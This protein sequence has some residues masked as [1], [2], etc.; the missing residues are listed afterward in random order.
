MSNEPRLPDVRRLARAVV[1]HI[2]GIF[3]LPLFLLSPFAAITAYISMDVLVSLFVI[4]IVYANI[5]GHVVLFAILARRRVLSLLEHGSDS[6]DGQDPVATT[7]S[8]LIRIFLIANVSFVLVNA[9]LLPLFYDFDFPGHVLISPLYIASF[10]LVVMPALLSSMV[11]RCENAVRGS[12]PDYTGVGVRIG[13]RL[14]WVVMLTIVGLVG[15]SLLTNYI[16]VVAPEIGREPPVT[17][18]VLNLILGVTSLAVIAVVVMQVRS[19]VVRPLREAI[20]AFEVALDGDFTVRTTATTLDEIGQL[21]AAADSFFRSMRSD[22]QTIG[23]VIRDL[24]Q[25]KSALSTQVKAVAESV[26]VIRSQLD[27]T[28][29]QMSDQTANMSE[30]TAAI[31]ELARNIDSLGDSISAQHDHVSESSASVRGLSDANTKLSAIAG[32]SQSSVARLTETTRS[33]SERVDAMLEVARVIASESDSLIDANRLI[34]SIAA[35]TNLLAMN[36]AI[37]AA[38]AGEA[39]RGFS[40]VADEIRKLAESASRQSK[41]ISTNLKTVIASIEKLSSDSASVRSGFDDIE[42]DIGNVNTL[43]SQL[44]GFVTQVE[45]IGVNVSQSLEQILDV[46]GSIQ[47]GS[48]EMRDGNR[49]MLN[50]AAQLKEI[51]LSVADA[52]DQIGGRSKTIADICATLEGHDAATGRLVEDLSSVVSRYTTETANTSEGL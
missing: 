25:D 32:S 8:A 21:S 20:R 50:A 48:S 23:A 16:Y 24:E 44:T 14:V 17:I 27:R 46:S 37:E 12:L 42:T 43:S 35:Q 30:T 34:A 39:G 47:T 10:Q 45:G 40:V 38:H 22:M 18:L 49:E 52:V 7:I 11:R 19:N 51:S 31:E 5:G 26:Q 33:S 1:L 36:A 6:D 15:M 2:V 4:P 3:V 41:T 28:S 13:F 29:E 9:V